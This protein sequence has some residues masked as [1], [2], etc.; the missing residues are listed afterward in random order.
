MQPPALDDRVNAGL[1]ALDRHAWRESYDLLSA[2][3]RDALLG[4]AEL[5]QLGIAA[6]WL[7]RLDDSLETPWNVSMRRISPPGTSVAVGAVRSSSAICDGG[8]Q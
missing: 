8:T 5:E 2:A 1:N 6:W 3:D 4:G 7:G